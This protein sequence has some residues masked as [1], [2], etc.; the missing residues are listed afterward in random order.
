M[1]HHYQKHLKLHKVLYRRF[2]SSQHWVHIIFFEQ[3]HHTNSIHSIAF[4]TQNVRARE[5]FVV[6][7]T[8]HTFLQK[9]Y[10]MEE[11]ENKS[12]TVPSFKEVTGW[13]QP[14]VKKTNTIYLELIQGKPKT[15]DTALYALEIMHKLFVLKLNY[16]HVVVC[17]DGKTVNLLYKIKDEYGHEMEWLLVI[18]GPWYLLKNISTYLSKNMNMS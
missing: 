15:L 10:N 7:A 12:Q 5:D 3:T 8:L 16:R 2:L 18:L 14:V 4:F 6:K 9:K 13:E 17:R 1:T 11:D